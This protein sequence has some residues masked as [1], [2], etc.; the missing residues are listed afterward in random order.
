MEYFHNQLPTAESC[1]RLKKERATTNRF[2]RM[3]RMFKAARNRLAEKKMLSKNDAPSC[4]IECLLYNVPDG[5]FN[6]DLAPTY[7][8]ILGWLK[9]AQ[10]KEFAYQ[11]DQMPLFGR[12]REQW[13]VQKAPPFLMDLQG[14][15]EVGC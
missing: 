5:M 7:T 2:K 10:V 15:W 8:G 6:R 12:G 1:P 9:K 11:N 3:T 14:L 13:S 4:F